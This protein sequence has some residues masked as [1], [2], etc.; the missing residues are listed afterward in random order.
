MGGHILGYGEM[1]AEEGAE[2]F[3]H[4]EEIRLCGIQTSPWIGDLGITS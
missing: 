3:L 2:E 1:V 4:G